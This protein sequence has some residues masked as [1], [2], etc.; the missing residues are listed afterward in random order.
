VWVIKG[1]TKLTKNEALSLNTGDT[2]Y[3]ITGKIQNGFGEY[4][5]AATYSKHISVTRMK[6]TT[7]GVEKCH[8]GKITIEGNNISLSCTKG[9]APISLDSEHVWLTAKERYNALAK[10]IR[11]RTPKS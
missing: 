5:I 3:G 10:Q 2:I 11:K 6:P 7:I 1:A 4:S 8:V 9:K